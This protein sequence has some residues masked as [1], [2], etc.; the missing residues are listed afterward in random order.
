MTAAAPAVRLEPIPLA[1]KAEL[2]P[3]LDAYLT[4]HADLVDPERQYGD[5]TAYSPYDLYW[6]EPG[7]TPYWIVADGARVGF[8]LVNRYSASGRGCDAAIAE[9]HVSNDRRRQG[10][11]EAAALA[12]FATRGGLWELQVFHANAGGAIF[13]PRVIARAG[14]RAWEQIR[15]E[16]R[17]I[18]RFTP[19]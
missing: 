3:Q 13:W 4:A 16:D 11:G 10:L 18:H 1:Q 2:R 8:V 9:F 15:L 14:T 6:S 5:P 17:T 12:A 19:N 7:R